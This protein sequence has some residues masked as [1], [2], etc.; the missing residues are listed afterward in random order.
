MARPCRASAPASERVVLEDHERSRTGRC[1]PVRRS[2]TAPGPA[3]RS[4]GA[5]PDWAA[6]RLP[7]PVRQE[8]L[9]STRTRV[10]RVLMNR[11]IIEV[12]PGSSAG[13]PETVV[14]NTTSSPPPYRD[15]SSARTLEDG[16]Q[17]EPRA[18]GGL[19]QP[20]R[21]V[22]S[23][24]IR[25]AP[26]GRRGGPRRAVGPGAVRWAPGGGEGLPPVPFGPVGVPPGQPAQI[27]GEGPALRSPAGGA[28]GCRPRAARTPRRRAGP[29]SAV[30]QDVVEG[31][32]QGAPGPGPAG[33]A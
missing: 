19:P 23:R 18:L 9:P 32:Q 16:V 31:P 28:R 26:E 8:A 21:D 1:R 11:P 6:C 27:V 30:E 13:R 4:R 12:T 24:V 7:Q 2:T 17:G 29:R 3:R 14:P 22:R 20:R 10:G 15:S 5:G 25:T 33:S